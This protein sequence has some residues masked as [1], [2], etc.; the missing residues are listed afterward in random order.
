M[1]ACPSSIARWRCVVLLFSLVIIVPSL[2]DAQ[3]I[4]KGSG[5]QRL[6]LLPSQRRELPPQAD[7][8]E[9]FGAVEKGIVG[10][11]VDSFARHFASPIYLNLQGGE[12]G[13]FSSSQA[14][15]ILDSYLRTRKPV[16]FR[17]STI[18]SLDKSPFATGSGTF[19]KKGAWEIGQV[20]VSLAPS[21]DR[22]LITQ[23]NIY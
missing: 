11:S 15:Y 12:T 9:V 10:A 1:I 6:N 7:A 18:G 13:S 4:L 2:A 17:F 8:R 14:F 20:Y 23:I 22:W 16:G 5:Q 3:T 21:G 19:Q